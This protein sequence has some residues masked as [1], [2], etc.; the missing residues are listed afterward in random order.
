MHTLELVITSIVTILAAF[1]GAWFGAKFA[2][3]HGE[4][5]QSTCPAFAAIFPC[6]QFHHEEAAIPTSVLAQPQR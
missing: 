4:K 1:I 3:K 6:I 5:T 2:A